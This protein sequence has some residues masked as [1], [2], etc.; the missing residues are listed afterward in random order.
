MERGRVPCTRTGSSRLRID[1]EVG[2]IKTGEFVPR[3]WRGS[4]EKGPICSGKWSGLAKIAP[5]NLPDWCACINMTTGA[6]GAS[7]EAKDAGA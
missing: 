1:F 2:N 5:C 3:F 6:A 4:L 7:N